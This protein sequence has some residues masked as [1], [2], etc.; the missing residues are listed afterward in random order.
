MNRIFLSGNLGV[1]PELKVTNSDKEVVNFTLATK[2]WK[3][4]D[5]GNNTVTTWHNV[6]AWGNQA[7]YA[8]NYL[9]KGDECL[10]EGRMEYQQYTDQNGNKK[11]KAI[12]V[13]NSVKGFKKKAQTEKEFKI[14]EDD[15]PF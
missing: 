10:I 2:G 9:K 6:T 15:L 3:K 12:V 5:D 8:S 1:N 14:D 7:K 4:S 13:A 11:N